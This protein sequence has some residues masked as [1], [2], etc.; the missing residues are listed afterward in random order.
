M[1]IG[2]KLALT[3]WGAVLLAFLIAGVTLLLFESLTLERRARKMEGPY[4]Q[5]VSVGTETAVSFQNSDR[6]QEILDTLRTN[7]DILEAEI[8]LGSGELLAAFNASGGQG[9][10]NALKAPGVYIVGD[11]A[12]F[13]HALK[14][15]AH[16]RIVMGLEQLKRD[17]H[18]LMWLF[19]ISVVVLM[20]I[21]FG[22]LA[23]L[24]RTIVQPISSLAEAVEQVRLRGDYGQR[25][26]ASG[27]DEVARLGQSFNAMMATVQER[28]DDL[29]KLNQELDQRVRDRTVQLESANKELEAFSY[30]VSH[31]LRAPL[32][33]IDGFSRALLED[34]SDKL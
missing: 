23:V 15:G 12:E 10:K 21:T 20:A 16:L 19:G 7:P 26:E 6:A 18:D 2:K 13:V 4:L 29:R 32:R 22:L 27:T 14:D 30:S 9:K 33:S 11:T 28:D 24:R 25:V 31:D 17:S 8:I 34:Y 5:L 1:S 3:L